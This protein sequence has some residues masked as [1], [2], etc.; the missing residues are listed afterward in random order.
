[1]L[2]TF[3][4]RKGTTQ[5]LHDAQPPELKDVG[6]IVRNEPAQNAL[7]IGSAQKGDT[8]EKS[9][10]NEAGVEFVK[11]STGGG[12]VYIDA[13]KDLWLDFYLPNTSNKVIKLEDS[14]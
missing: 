2:W 11:R 7:V 1:M 6:L 5:Q 14:F 9:A 10:L 12:V 3:E 8:I 4:A 13:A